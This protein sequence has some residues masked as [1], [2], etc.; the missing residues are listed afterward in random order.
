MD[1]TGTR[2]GGC[3]CG[4]VRYSVPT[5]P[6]M[7]VACHCR[8]C[9]RQSGSAFALVAI[10]PLAAVTIEGDLSH[11]TLTGT[12]GN[13]LHR[14]FCA[15]CGSPIYSEGEADRES[16]HFT[17]NAGTLDYTNDLSPQLH[18]WT[19]SKQPWVTLPSDSVCAAQQ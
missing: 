2:G 12:S 15:S 5:K 6:E 8:D 18:I 9:Q 7:V 11:F 3:L 1:D 17:L 16:G 10:Y 13:S 4:K 19:D 14:Y